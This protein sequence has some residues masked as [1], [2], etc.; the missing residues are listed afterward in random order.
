MFPIVTAA[1]AAY[2]MPLATTLRSVVDNN[3]KWWPWVIYVL[4]DGFDTETKLRVERSLPSG[5][6]EIQWIQID[7]SA[8]AG[9]SSG[10]RNLSK[11]TY[12]RLLVPRVI[13]EDFERVLYLDA[14]IL[15]IDN[16]EALWKT[17]L[18]GAPFA[19][20][21]DLYLHTSFELKGIEPEIGRLNHPEFTNLPPIRNY[22]NAGVLLINLPR[23]REH[24]ISEKALAFLAANP[25]TSNVDQDA[26]NVS[27]NG[28]WKAI[29]GRW[30]FQDSYSTDP[31][32]KR[33]AI[34]HF[35]TQHKPWLP[36]SRHRA[37]GLYDSYR[38]RTRFAR[39]TKEKLLHPFQRFAAG[40]KNIQKR[41]IRK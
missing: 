16:L 17:N 10:P 12:A 31:R 22:C 5:S 8:F 30:N 34:V 28:Q 40:I 3:P 13:P 29:S 25:H 39:S 32:E 24:M 15:V 38:A 21:S 18:I 36:Q 7:M 23:W 6:A 33:A 27:A 41:G 35:V 20:V 4:S 14:D 1:N 9:F 2:A 11:M 19:A 37:F 26:I